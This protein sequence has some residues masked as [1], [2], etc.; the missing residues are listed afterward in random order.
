MNNEQSYILSSVDRGS[1]LLELF[2]RLFLK[3]VESI[4]LTIWGHLPNKLE[5]ELNKFNTHQRDIRMRLSRERDY[6][7]TQEVLED[8]LK[9]L[10]S[11][12]FDITNWGVKIND[13]CSVLARSLD[14]V[15]VVCKS[16]A[17]QAE[18]DTLISE[19]KKKNIIGHCEIIQNYA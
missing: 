17:L 2:V 14:D 3:Q 12:N 1:S 15:N 5:I 9:I 10:K 6:Y 11:T 8:Y 7:I 13:K 18:V 19:L 16:T 4:T